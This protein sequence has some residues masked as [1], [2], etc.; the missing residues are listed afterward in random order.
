MK[1]PWY[2]VPKNRVKENVKKYQLFNFANFDSKENLNHN[3][4][5]VQ[6]NLNFIELINKNYIW[7]GKLLVFLLTLG[8]GSFFLCLFFLKLIF[9]DYGEF[10]I[11]VYFGAFMVCGGFLYIFLTMLFPFFKKDFLKKI[12]NPIIV[13]RKNNI[14]FYFG[15][16]DQLIEL[17]LDELY[18]D[19]FKTEGIAGLPIYELHAYIV[20][21]D[22]I[23]QDVQIG[24]PSF[25]KDNI[26]GL[27]GFIKTYIEQGPESLYFRHGVDEAEID[28]FK[29][30]T[31][32][33]DI[34]DKRESF[35]QS[36]ETVYVNHVQTPLLSIFFA[37]PEFIRFICRRL[38][39][40]F[41]KK[42]VWP[43]ELKQKNKIDEDDPYIVKAKD[44]LKFGF[45]KVRNK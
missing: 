17:D 10:D 31:Y 32:C 22:I 4:S 8:A 40:I 21:N 34:Y 27:L 45:M 14:L 5:F 13:S 29:K 1:N 38:T 36:W 11:L 41:S 3:F 2:F 12:Y 25:F 20:E 16:N 30:L 42:T 35:K 44:N 37:I 28:G 9:I 39:L 33:Y 23:V 15:E 6:M 7:K 24:A 43:V 26:E 19:F 18:F